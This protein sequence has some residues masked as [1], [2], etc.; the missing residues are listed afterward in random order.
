METMQLYM[1]SSSGIDSGLLSSILLYAG[2]AGVIVFALIVITV[3]RKW[4]VDS[5]IIKMAKD[6]REM[7]ERQ[8]GLISNYQT[9]KSTEQ[10]QTTSK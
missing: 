10:N 9:K 6:I 3:V 2:I 8:K 7:N 5:A 4:R 1:G